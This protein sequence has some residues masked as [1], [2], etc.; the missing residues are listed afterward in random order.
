MA[1]RAVRRL[2]RHVDRIHVPHHDGDE[3]AGGRESLE[4]QRRQTALLEG[5]AVRT[6]PAGIMARS[7]AGR[8]TTT[9]G[10]EKGEGRSTVNDGEKGEG[11]CTVRCE[12]NLPY[13]TAGTSPFSLLPKRAPHASAATTRALISSAL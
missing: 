9:N 8:T 3:I 10:G 4:V 13:G 7:G 6:R 11:R 2:R 5:A 1:D 12:P